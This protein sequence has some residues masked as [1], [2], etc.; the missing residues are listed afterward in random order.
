MCL[1]FTARLFD[2][3][4]G[5]PRVMWAGTCDEDV[6]DRCGELVEEPPE[7]LEVGCV[8]RGD[9]GFKLD[10]GTVYPVGVASRDDHGGSL[11]PSPPSGLEPDPGAATDHQQ[12]LAGEVLITPHCTIHPHG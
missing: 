6:V 3:E 8:E 5:Q 7:A 2:V 4:L 1:E 12:L 10:A 11:R 9:A